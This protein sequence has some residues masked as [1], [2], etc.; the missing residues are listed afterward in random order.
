MMSDE[1]KTNI[2]AADMSDAPTP[3]EEASAE[4][5]HAEE[6]PAEHAT[7][8]ARVAELEGQLA[9]ERTAATEY[10]NRWQRAQADFANFKRRVQQEQDQAGRLIA[11]QALAAV[12]PAMDSFERA[13]SS[14]PVTLR[15]Y[16]W[17]DGVALV[18]LQLD[19]ALRSAGVAPITAEAGA[20]FDPARHQAISEVETSEHPSG[21]IAV[22][23]QRG[24]EVGGVILRPTLV[25]VARAPA[26]QPAT[27][28]PTG[29]EAAADPQPEADD[30]SP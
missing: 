17:I 9:A 22:V 28:A 20:P 30:A 8:E 4:N 3:T 14:L 10:M 15:Q 5:A 24:Y 7:P 18:Q 2:D 13:F 23:V 6:A 21:H 25:Q 19:A 11:A 12:L 1:P 26:A 29:A 16:S 27:E